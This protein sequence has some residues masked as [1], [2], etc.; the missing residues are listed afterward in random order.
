MN[1]RVWIRLAGG[2]VLGALIGLLLI[3]HGVRA[4]ALLVRTTPEAGAELSTAP[5][6]LE[7]WFSE[8]LEDQ[9]SNIYLVDALGNEFGRGA[10]TVDA[11][12]SFHM[13]LPLAELPP[14]IYTVIWRT[15]SQADGHEWVGSFPLTILLPDGTRPAS[16]GATAGILPGDAQSEEL[17]TPLHATSRWLMLV[18]AMLLFGVLF[19][20]TQLGSTALFQASKSDG[21][22]TSVAATPTVFHLAARQS[23]LLLLLG[24]AAALILGG[25]LQWLGQTYALGDPSALLDLI[26]TTRSGNLLLCRQFLASVLLLGA[27]VTFLRADQSGAYRWVLGVAII[28]TGVT[29]AA[30]GWLTT[31]RLEPFILVSAGLGLGGILAALLPLPSAGKA[32]A[33]SWLPLALGVAALATFSLGS[34]AAAVAGRGWAILGDLLHLLAAAIWFGGLLL[35]ALLLWRLRGQ[36]SLSDT[37]ALRQGVARFSAIATV[38]V[39]WLTVT[40]IFSSFVQ[41]RAW[42]QVWTTTYGWMLLVK[43]VLVGLTL[44]LALLNHRFVHGADAE[45]WTIVDARPFLRRV[46]SEAIV[47]LVLMVVVAIL[48]QVPVPIPT[49][50]APLTATLPFQEILSADDLSIHLQISPNLVGNNQYQTHLSHA[51][52]S[53]IG[54]VQ[55]VQLRFVHTELG[56]ASLDLAPL[57]SGL[58][59]AEGAYQNRAG[60]WEVSVYVRRRGMDDSLVTTT[61]NTPAAAAVSAPLATH[62]W[63]SPVPAWPPDAPIVGLLA[64]IGIAVAI[65]RWMMR[66]THAVTE[67]K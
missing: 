11:A 38:A 3:C 29:L 20:R 57:G 63:Q 52:G 7:L 42:N 25:W 48:V 47:S 60:P 14:G 50:A 13:T 40:G 36:R 24:A 59:G 23:V 34:H 2:G 56:Q 17:P 51:D 1:Q 66:K 5:A 27:V 62:L 15:L 41:L 44:A 28:Y 46:W 16:T 4:H 6:L 54:E 21:R 31:Q 53:P 8:P 26:F 39:F 64:S 61:V 10:S 58:F 49:V 22:Q 12:D 67:Q 30:I 65:W 9:F 35:L 45:R 33:M 43:L 18:G 37:L 19:L 55:L 32:Q